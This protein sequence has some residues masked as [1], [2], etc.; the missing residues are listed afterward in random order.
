MITKD[1]ERNRTDTMIYDQLARGCPGMPG[2]AQ[3]CPGAIYDFVTVEID[4]E[5]KIRTFL[6]RFNGFKRA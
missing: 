2:L 4:F 5:W 6:G 1:H 3:I